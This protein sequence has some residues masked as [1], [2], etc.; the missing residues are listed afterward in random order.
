M[1][2]RFLSKA[3]M[4]SSIATIL[5]AS[6]CSTNYA[7]ASADFAPNWLKEGVYAEYLFPSTSSVHVTPEGDVVEG[8]KPGA[9][10]RWECVDMN[11]TF[12]ELKITFHYNETDESETLIDET[13]KTI[14]NVCVNKFDRTVYLQNGTLL[15]TTLFWLPANPSSG[16]TVI[17]WN[18]PPDV[19]TFEIEEST[20]DFRTATPQGP[21]KYFNIDKMA[22]LADGTHLSVH[23]TFDFDTGVL[24]QGMMGHEPTF[25]PLELPLVFVSHGITLNDTNIDLGP[26]VNTLD[27]RTILTVIAIVVALAIIFVS[28]YMRRTK[29]M[30]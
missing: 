5:L 7:R 19:I 8:E 29:R 24:L 3:M 25:K 13:E 2:K 18:I 27:W 17:L 9:I 23:V 4:L 12:A 22:N 11:S 16:E 30:H 10:F 1:K 6:V 20:H 28:F 21:Q 14:F 15:G 26:S